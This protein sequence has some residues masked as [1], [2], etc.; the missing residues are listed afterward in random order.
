MKWALS[1]RN[2]DPATEME[3]IHSGI[4][5][6]FDDFFSLKPSAFFDTQWA[7]SVDVTEEDGKILIKAEMPG[8]TESDISVTLEDGMLTIS[9]EKKEERKEED[10]Y[11]NYI[12]SERS[13]GS[14][15][16]QIRMPKDIKPEKISAAFKNGILDISVPRDEKVQ[17]Q[18][19][20]IQAK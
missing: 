12:I 13:F 2:Q 6:F 16:R 20:Q 8:M 11:R 17:S 5:S 7:P 3:R 15:R 1:R 18:K 4:D 9:G 10:K 19:I 14:F